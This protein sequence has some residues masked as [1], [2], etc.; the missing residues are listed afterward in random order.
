MALEE[1]KLECQA[2][3]LN[4]YL[5]RFEKPETHE[6]LSDEQIEYLSAKGLKAD[7]AY[8]PPSSTAEK[9]DVYQARRFQ[10]KLAG[11]S[12][13]PKVEDILAKI[14]LPERE[15]KTVNATASQRLLA[16]AIHTCEQV[17]SLGETQEE[18][19][20]ELLNENKAKLKELRQELAALK[21][22][23]LKGGFWPFPSRQEDT[24]VVGGIKA[25][26]C[27]DVESVKI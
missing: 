27:V 16:N 12:S 7:G 20:G 13:I 3:S 26:F 2:K 19:L 18:I 9:V 5:K 17:F 15:G 10:I 14:V 1:Y 21:F 6:A 25:T 11:L 24:V 22:G 4:F 23:I 8:D